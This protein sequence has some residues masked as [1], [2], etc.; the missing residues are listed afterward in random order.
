MLLLIVLIDGIQ[1]LIPQLLL[2]VLIDGIQQ[3]IPDVI[4]N[5]FSLMV[6]N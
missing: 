1:Q 4:V 5:W 2:I 6:Y 3:L